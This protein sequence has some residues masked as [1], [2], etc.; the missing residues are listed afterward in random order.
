MGKS[1]NE[2]LYLI[3]MCQRCGEVLRFVERT[4]GCSS[5]PGMQQVIRQA[6]V[7]D[8][9]PCAQIPQARELSGHMQRVE[10]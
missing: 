7:Q 8:E 1:I 5:L 6:A 3:K 9:Q 4:D 2:S 10:W